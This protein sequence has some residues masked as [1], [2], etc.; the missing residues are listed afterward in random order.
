M[1]INSGEFL[2]SQIEQVSLIQ[3]FNLLEEIVA[4]K[5]IPAVVAEPIDIGNDVDVN[6]G[7]IAQ[8][9][10]NIKWRGIVERLARFLDQKGL[11][12][13]ALIISRFVF[14]EDSGFGA[15][16]H[17]IQAPQQGKRQNNLAI[18]GLFEI[19]SEQISNR[20]CERR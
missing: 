15:L 12:I 2:D 19:P 10:G 18:V 17:A 16:Q 11:E 1:Q 13:D 14:F 7:R 4:F 5:D 3:L 8:Q 20:P 9:L 6:M